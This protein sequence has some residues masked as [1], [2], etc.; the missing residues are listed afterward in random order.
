[1][2]SNT[3]QLIQQLIEDKVVAGISYAYV[4]KNCNELY[5]EGV[6]GVIDPFNRIPLSPAMQYD[7]ASVSKVVGTT[8]RIL[9]LIEEGKLSLETKVQTLLP[10]FR[11]DV[12]TIRNLLF[13]NAGLPADLADKDSLTADNITD[14]VYGAELVSKPGEVICYSDLGYILLGFIIEAVDGCTLE[15]SFRKNI[16]DPIGMNNTSFFPR[17]KENCVPTEVTEQRG[18]IQGETHD[19]KGFYLKQAGSAG[20]FSTLSDLV[21][22]VRSLLFD[23]RSILKKETIDYLF[24]V[25]DDERTLGWR[26]DIGEKTLYHTGFTGTS[27]LIDFK[28]GDALIMLAN[29]VHPNRD[30]QEFIDRR[31]I[32]DRTFIENHTR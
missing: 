3:R 6:Q 14:R 32:I 23:E 10:R 5:Y 18:C 29:R 2:D 9:Q 19:R 24:E 26:T 27:I 15:E 12:I 21:L 4:A 16:F 25:G 13:H 28:H 22:F 17:S 11:S 1:M 30:N 20:I 8:N 31:K 7:L